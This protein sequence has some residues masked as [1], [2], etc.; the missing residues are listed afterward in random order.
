MLVLNVNRISV[1]LHDVLEIDPKNMVVRVEPCVTIGEHHFQNLMPH[2]DWPQEHGGPGRALRHHRW[3]SFSKFNATPRLT[4]RT[5]WFGWSPALLSVNTIFKI[6]L[7]GLI[8]VDHQCH[9]SEA[10]ILKT[11]T[12]K[13]CTGPCRSLP[14]LVGSGYRWLV[15]DRESVPHLWLQKLTN[16]IFLRLIISFRDHF[17]PTI[18]LWKSWYK[19]CIGRDG[20]GQSEISDPD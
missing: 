10:P 19:I 5:W 20:S 6:Y 1:D 14:F 11:H 15:Q 18:S 9:L 12:V 2:L 3:A 7:A 4:P 8:I 13:Q 17:W 16:F